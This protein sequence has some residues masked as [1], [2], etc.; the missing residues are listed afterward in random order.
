MIK[1][2]L[3]KLRS[4]QGAEVYA[5]IRS[6]INTYKKQGINVYNALIKSFK[7]NTIIA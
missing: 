1:I 6:C 5:N 7:G 2:I 4:D 3:G